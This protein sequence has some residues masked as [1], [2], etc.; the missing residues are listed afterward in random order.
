MIT[1]TFAGLAVADYQAAYEWYVQLFGRAADMFPHDAEAV[2]RLTPTSAVYVVRDPERAGNGLI[3]VAVEN[4][5]EL[6]AR[7]RE[8]SIAFTELSAEGAPRRLVVED[9]DGNTVTYFQR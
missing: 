6:E 1:Y 4:L 5:A 9:R 2:W 7:L 8:A 3:T